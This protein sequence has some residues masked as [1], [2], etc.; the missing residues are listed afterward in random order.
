LWRKR[1]EMT[2]GRSPVGAFPNLIGRPVR[3]K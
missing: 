2:A 1:V 3:G